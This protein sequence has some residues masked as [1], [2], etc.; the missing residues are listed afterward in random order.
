MEFDGDPTNDSVEFDLVTLNPDVLDGQDPTSY[1]VSYYLTQADADAGTNGLPLLY[2]NVTNPQIIYIRVDN[3]TMVDDGTGTGNMV[4]SSDCYDTAE[5]TLEVNP[6]PSF[7]LE[8]NYLL[9]I[10]TN[11]TEV[12]NTPAVD[13]GLS[14]ADGYTFT[15]FL[16]GVE[17][18][19][20]A[21]M[22]SITP[23]EGGNYS[24]VVTSALG[25]S[26]IVGDPNTVTFVEVS[27]PPVVTAE[28][29]T[30]AFAEEHNIQVTATTT[31]SNAISVYEFS[32]DGG[33]WEANTPN[34]GMYTFTN[35]EAG[36]H[37]ITVRDAIG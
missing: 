12:I 28:I 14:P 6:M 26:T 32:I 4:D 9:C 24:V 2:N 25:C 18:P 1:T 23:T 31:A 13:T 22:G 17:Q 8:D 3:D 30:Q 16:E 15:W 20:Y 35:V 5:A 7:D 33:A 11:G 27:E 29:L 21:N 34:D 37:T 10:N 36:A 19:Q